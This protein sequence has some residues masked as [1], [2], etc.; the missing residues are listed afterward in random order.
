MSLVVSPQTLQDRARRF[1]ETFHDESYEKGETSTF[2]NDFFDIFERSRRDVARY[3]HQVKNLQGNTAFIDLFWP[4]VLL[5]EQKSTGKD[6][7]VAM[8]QAEEY[9][10]TLSVREKP[11]Y[12]LACDFQT[13]HLLDLD[14]KTDHKFDLADLPDNIHLFH[15]MQV[16]D[17]EQ[18]P[19]DPVSIEAS[20]KMALLHDALK[21]NRY[22]QSDM[23]YLLTRITFCLFADYVDIFKPGIFWNY[24]NK[25]Q[26]AGAT[27]LGGKLVKL[28]DTLN[29]DDQ[30]REKNLPDELKEFP[31]VNGDLFGTRITIP[32][33]DL[34]SRTLLFEAA[35]FD[36]SKISPAIFG[37]LFQS[38]MSGA[39]RRSTGAHYT[40]EENIM[41]VINPLFL[42]ELQVEFET[43]CKKTNR[44]KALEAFQDKLAKL[45]FFDPACGAGNF[46]IIA[47]REI[48]RLE[49]EVIKR[50][51]TRD[52]S[53]N[54][55]LLSKV[56]VDQFYG[57]EINPFSAK[58]AETSMWMMDHMMNRE[59]G[60]ALG[61]VY[62]RIPIKKSPKIMCGDALEINWNDVLD[63]VKCS[64]VLGNP[65]F[66]GSKKTSKLQKKQLLKTTGK[67]TLDYVCC[68]FA[69][70]A[71]YAAHYTRVGLV[72][73]NST[74]HGE[75]VG[76]FW[77]LLERHGMVMDFAYTTFAWD[78]DTRGKA[79]VHVVILGFC[80]DNKRAKRLFLNDVEHNP[81][82][83]SPYLLGMSSKS[84]I[85]N[86]STKALNGLPMMRLGTMPID[87]GNY[88]FTKQE[89]EEFLRVEP[90]A[91]KYFRPY[92]NADEFINGRQRWILFL[93]DTDP[94]DM[95][96]MPHVME[97]VRIVE[98]MRKSSSREATR[99]LP[100]TEFDLDVIPDAPFLVIPRVSSETRDYVPIGYLKPPMIPSDATLVVEHASIGL[101]GLLISRMHMV[102][103][104]G[105]GGK[106]TSRYRYSKGIVYNTF[107]VPDGN[108]D[109]LETYAKD[110]LNARKKHPNSTLADLYDR[111]AMPSELRRAHR[112]LDRKVDRM[113]RSSGFKSDQ[114]R[115]GCLLELYDKM[116]TG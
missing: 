85:V 29:R 32:N 67:T 105:I 15:F 26:K 73:T 18:L 58:I 51:R 94:A 16:N 7:K 57:I 98:S 21:E 113:Y 35:K 45:T 25:D 2:Y 1:A 44:R 54:A 93:R 19:T 64:Y 65:P 31:Y 88:T 63:S 22:N 114:E 109:A 62:A 23:E 27:E 39:E 9:Y 74:T 102:W 40:P 100:P 33:F 83:I 107:P 68:W 30:D 34:K 48:R 70:A 82:Y 72:S 79:H 66:G 12:I 43:I 50:M 84:P 71:E 99:S 10:E 101:F 110:V 20:Y 108:L 106:L 13:W 104:D 59:L 5:V 111:R 78:S 76:L 55:L 116:Q 77:P 41:K 80:K 36:W 112:A 92:I 28:F 95:R 17:E 8:E 3:E 4:G 47:Y 37:S 86:T 75:Q 42:D 115:L 81:A 49:T 52:K 90:R 14:S 53:L 46:L 11:R 89:K 96:R 69:K 60:D 91:A 103:L 87:G 61:N 97:R 38:T 24:I 56:D 6:L